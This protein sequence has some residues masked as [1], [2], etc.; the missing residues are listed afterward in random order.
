MKKILI[1]EDNIIASNSLLLQ[2]KDKYQVNVAEDAINAISMVSRFEPDVLLLDI[3]SPNRDEF[4]VLECVRIFTSTV[5]LPTIFISGYK[6]EAFKQRA[7]ILGAHAFFEKPYE[8]K[9]LLEAIETMRQEISFKKGLGLIIGQRT[10]F[11]IEHVT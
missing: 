1:V 11:S 7:K 4:Q 2:L 6:D 10:R 3:N 9:K 8:F 5:G